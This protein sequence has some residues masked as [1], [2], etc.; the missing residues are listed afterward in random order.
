[1][2]EGLL[3][4]NWGQNPDIECL[5]LCLAEKHREG[6]HWEEGRKSQKLN[7]VCCIPRW[8]DCRCYPFL[9]KQA[10]PRSSGGKRALC[11]PNTARGSAGIN[12]SKIETEPETT[13]RYR[14]PVAGQI[15]AISL[16]WTAK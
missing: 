13:I 1:M 4:L 12:S 9:D 7:G 5:R 14:S 10:S 2:L 16:R 6:G 3:G 11:R 8:C 15:D